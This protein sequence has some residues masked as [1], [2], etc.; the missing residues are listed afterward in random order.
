MPKRERPG[1][2][3]CLMPGRATSFQREC[4]LDHMV[5]G[6]IVGRGQHNAQ[7]QRADW[8]GVFP[9]HP[10]D[11]ALRGDADLLEEPTQGQVEAIFVQG[12]P[13]VVPG[14]VAP[15]L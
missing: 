6:R 7:T 4:L 14:P 5:Q 8:T 11:L 12:M 13:P 2:Q 9:D 1:R 3:P 10:L 15:G